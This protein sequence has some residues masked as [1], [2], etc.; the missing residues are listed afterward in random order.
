MMMNRKIL[1]VG[2]LLF[3]TTSVGAYTRVYV[4]EEAGFT[5]PEKIAEFMFNEERQYSDPRLGYGLNYWYKDKILVTV[6]VYNQGLD[7]IKDGV[8]GKHVVAELRQGQKDIEL[9]VEKKYYKSAT[10]LTDLDRFPE[11]FLR[12][13]YKIVA[14]NGTVKRSHL[15]IRGK[16]VIL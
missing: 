7:D 3:L 5:F 14:D 13:S 15:L 10:K 8:T 4:D 2:I 11:S 6:I 16:M 1:W 12:S 9:M